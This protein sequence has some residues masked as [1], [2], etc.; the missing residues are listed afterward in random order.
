MKPTR[1]SELLASFVEYC[2][3]HPD[4]RFWQALRNWAGINFVL[5][6]ELPPYELSKQGNLVDT[7]AWEVRNELE[8]S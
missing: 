3:L 5:A 4:L 6:S 8:A 7:Y 2:T 1:N